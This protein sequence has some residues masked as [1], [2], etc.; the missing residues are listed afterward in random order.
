MGCIAKKIPR[1][2]NLLPLPFRFIY[3]PWTLSFLWNV[4]NIVSLFLVFTSIA[5]NSR[6]LQ[7]ACT[8]SHHWPTPT[9][10][11]TLIALIKFPPYSIDLATS[12]TLQLFTS[13]FILYLP[14][15]NISTFMEQYLKE[16]FMSYI[17]IMY[18]LRF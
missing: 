15:R 5:F 17:D 8:A 13:Y 3:N 4:P 18:I 11:H 2:I 16:S 9:T 6:S 1:S 7:N 10:A 12:F 14:L